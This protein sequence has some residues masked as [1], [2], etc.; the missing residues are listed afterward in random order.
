LDDPYKVLGVARDAT[1]DEIRKAY[2]KLAKAHHPDLNPGNAK[3]EDRFKAASAA[4]E[5][6]SDP[7]KRR[8]FDRGEIDGEGQEQARPPPY[9]QY[10]DSESG[11]GYRAGGPTAAD[12]NHNDLRDMF[13]S[14]FSGERHSG[15]G[16]VRGH[17]ER[18]V[19]TAE[20]TDAINGAN[21]RLTLP[22][23]R[24]LDV[25]I[26]PGTDDGPV[27]RLRGQGEAGRTG[28]ANGYILIEISVARHKYFK[29]SGQ[30][31]M[32]DLPVTVAEAVLGGQ[33]E[34]PT[35]GG[36][37]RMRIPP[38]SD[39][40][41]E[42]RLRG[43]GVPKHGGMA[44]GD[45]YATLRIEIGTSDKSMQEFLRDWKPEIPFDPRQ[46]MET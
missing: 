1:A 30:D 32:L 2:R 41:T 42:L 11:R 3:A 33:I 5:I 4:N 34:V 7:A 10:A 12:W 15:T 28:G 23:G 26:P 43:K 8:Q 38:G 16:P 17:D 13:G 40:G 36:R 39:Y 6:L 9:Q 22:D 44:A 31:I 19:L 20:F 14:M 29:R 37:V 25:K 21:R 18:Y 46:S 27:L 35:P 24:V 45:L